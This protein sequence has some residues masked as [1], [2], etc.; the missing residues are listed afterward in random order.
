MQQHLATTISAVEDLER[1]VKAAANNDKK[2]MKESIARVTS[3][4]K[5]ADKLRRDDMQELAR[6]EL[7][8]HHTRLPDSI[9]CLFQHLL[10]DVLAVRIFQRGP[11]RT[12]RCGHDRRVW[13]HANLSESSIPFNSA[14][15]DSHLGI[16][17]DMVVE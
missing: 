15:F 2:K 1:A 9:I 7:P 8:P 14:R 17:F 4:E 13:A 5:E 12:G 16:L 3:A 6:G 10:C 11:Q